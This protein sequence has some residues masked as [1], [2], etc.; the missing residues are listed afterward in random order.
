[1]TIDAT[2]EAPKECGPHQQ[3]IEEYIKSKDQDGLIKVALYTS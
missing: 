2:F 1:M 3:D